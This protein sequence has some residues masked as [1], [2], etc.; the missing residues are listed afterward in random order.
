MMTLIS[1]MML[2]FIFSASASAGVGAG[3]VRHDRGRGR[4]CGRLD[5]LD[6]SASA[7]VCEYREESR[8]VWYSR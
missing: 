2:T 7:S 3:G 8:Y 5:F 4:G 1:V 6:V